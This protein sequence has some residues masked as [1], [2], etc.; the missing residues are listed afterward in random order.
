MIGCSW[1]GC[2]NPIISL[3]HVCIVNLH[4]VY[5]SKQMV[6]CSNIAVVCIHQFMSLHYS[7][8]FHTHPL[9][10]FFPCPI[11]PARFPAES[12]S[13]IAT[14]GCADSYQ[15]FPL[16]TLVG[17]SVYALWIVTW[18]ATPRLLIGCSWCGCHNPIIS[19]TH[20]IEC[21]VGVLKSS[22][23]PGQSRKQATLLT[24][25]SGQDSLGLLCSLGISFHV[26]HIYA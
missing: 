1:C 9:A 18:I 4:M 6:S 12:R 19:L 23:P 3:V 15:S 10:R 11:G 20:V 22:H 16:N 7:C 2:N 21:A 5:N 25:S 8:V 24:K 26:H 13:A 14:V 17:D